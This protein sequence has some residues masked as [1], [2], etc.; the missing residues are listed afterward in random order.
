MGVAKG[1][2][3]GGIFP[4]APADARPFDVVS[5]IPTLTV[6]ISYCKSVEDAREIAAAEFDWAVKMG[7]AN[8]K[9]VG[10]ECCE[11]RGKLSSPNLLTTSHSSPTS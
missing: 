5:E 11:G 1:I 9:R 2:T 8:K 7:V 6:P 3:V 4:L 10:M